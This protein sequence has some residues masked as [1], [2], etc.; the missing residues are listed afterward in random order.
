MYHCC[1][2]LKERN[3]TLIVLLL[4]GQIRGLSLLLL[5]RSFLVA[6]TLLCHLPIASRHRHILKLG[7]STGGILLAEVAH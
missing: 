6:L 2:L 7:E 5:L 4:V 1:F 3:S